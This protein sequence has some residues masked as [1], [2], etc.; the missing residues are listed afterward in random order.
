MEYLKT[1]IKFSIILFLIIAWMIGIFVFSN[2]PS[3]ESNEKSKGMINEVVSTTINITNDSGITDKHPSEKRMNSVIEKL[4]KPLRK[5]MHASVYFILSI[6]IF[7]GL[8]TFKVKGLKISM[9][10]ILVCFLYACTDEFH[11]SF[12]N[13]RTSEFT[14]VLI[15]T[16]GAIVGIIIINIIFKICYRIKNKC[17]RKSTK[18]R[19][20]KR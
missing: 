14:D 9:I 6:L 18:I 11:Q 17:W 1:N 15:D 20:N 13:G 7:L 2:M 12:V 19:S 5:C 3:D 8:K 16:L 4:N 10:P